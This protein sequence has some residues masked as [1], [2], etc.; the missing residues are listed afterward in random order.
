M[1]F[2]NL[3]HFPTYPESDDLMD[4]NEHVS[5]STMKEVSGTVDLRANAN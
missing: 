5:A 2:L 4:L 3:G 1:R